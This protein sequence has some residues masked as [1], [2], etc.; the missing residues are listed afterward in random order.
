MG[1]GHQDVLGIASLLVE[2]CGREGTAGHG[3]RLKGWNW[4]RTGIWRC[5]KGTRHGIASEG[6]GGPEAGWQE[7]K[8]MEKELWAGLRAWGEWWYHQ[9]FL[10]QHHSRPFTIKATTLWVN[11]S[12]LMPNFVALFSRSGLLS[13]STVELVGL[14]PPVSCPQCRRALSQCSVCFK[15]SCYMLPLE[16]TCT[17]AG[18]KSWFC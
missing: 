16:C 17:V 5:K 2:L 3:H 7:L 12:S 9:L 13:Q 1:F 4:W 8:D 15:Q 18:A 10:L 11:F 14:Q 6:N